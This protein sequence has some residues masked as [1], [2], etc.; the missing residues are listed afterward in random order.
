MHSAYLKLICVTALVVAGCAMFI[1]MTRAHWWK[2]VNGA[3]VVYDGQNLPSADV[4]RSPNGELLVNLSKLPDE[5]ALFVIYPSEN[6][7]GLPNEKH[8][9]FLPGYAYS[10][11][12]TPLV[13]F[14]NSVKAET[15]PKVVVS[16]DSVEFT[17]L[18]ERRVQIIVPSATIR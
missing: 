6:K 10:R 3:R 16:Q 13:V 9:I 1:V 18:R 15:D 4:F 14:M 17:T 2:K 5:R 7:V 12:V 11:Y 8:F